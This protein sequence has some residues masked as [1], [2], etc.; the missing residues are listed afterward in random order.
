MK[1][2]FLILATFSTSTL[3]GQWI[4]SDTIAANIIKTNTN[5]Y[6]KINAGIKIF[7]AELYI[8]PGASIDLLKNKEKEEFNIIYDSLDIN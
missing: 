1:H 8:S 3:W 5:E 6:F 4:D 2:L 7:K